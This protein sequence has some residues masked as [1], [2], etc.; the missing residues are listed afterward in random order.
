MSD[1]KN[2]DHLT[3]DELR[4]LQQQRYREAVGEGLF[5]KLAEIGRELGWDPASKDEQGNPTFKESKHGPKRKWI[6]EGIEIYVDDY[7]FYGY[8]TV[9]VNGKQ[10]ACNHRTFDSQF[11]IRGEWLDKVLPFHDDAI[12]KRGEKL[13]NQDASERQNLLSKL[14]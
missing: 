9:K 8:V 14:Q 5:R 12:V 1:Q 6:H 11:F 13:A 4:D 3:I 7:Y 2:L 10:V